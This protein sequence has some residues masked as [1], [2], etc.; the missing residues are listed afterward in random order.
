MFCNRLR[1]ITSSISSRSSFQR[2]SVNF[3]TDLAR[4]PTI[5]GQRAHRPRV[6][7]HS[8]GLVPEN[9]DWDCSLPLFF[10]PQHHS[11]HADLSLPI[12]PR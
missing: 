4:Q 7:R 6:E 9:A 3:T 12:S 10:V 1:L 5:T 11:S 8:E 2:E